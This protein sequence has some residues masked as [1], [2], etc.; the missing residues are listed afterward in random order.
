MTVREM[1]E[2][3][4]QIAEDKGFHRGRT[5]QGRD[6]TLVRLCLV[7]SEVTEAVQIVKKQFHDS[8]AY[9]QALP[10]LCEFVEELADVMIR[11]MDLAHCCGVNLESAIE[12]K[13]EKNRNRPE[14][15]GTLKE[16][17]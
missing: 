2:T 14:M 11:V 16:A 4:W 1:Q 17:K 3:A 15:Y 10:V 6:D 8:A 5:G 13:F 7:H 12:E 9:P